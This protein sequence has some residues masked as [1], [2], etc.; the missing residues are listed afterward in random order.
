MILVEEIPWLHFVK[1]NSIRKLS[2]NEQVSAYRQHLCDIEQIRACG[3]G[4]NNFSKQNQIITE[5]FLQQEDLFYLLQEDGSKI[6]IT[7]EI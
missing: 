7:T 5:G 4:S 3:G 1:L 2:L 6:Y